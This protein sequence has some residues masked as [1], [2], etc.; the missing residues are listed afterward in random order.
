MFAGVS[1][2]IVSASGPRCTDNASAF[3]PRPR[4]ENIAEHPVCKANG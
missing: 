4:A 2:E 3:G 1:T